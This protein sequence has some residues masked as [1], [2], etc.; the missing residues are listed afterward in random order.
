MA[1]E[2]EIKDK[3]EIERM[4]SDKEITFSHT[5]NPGGEQIRFYHST[6]DD[7]IYFHRPAPSPNTLYNPTYKS[8]APK[9]IKGNY[10]GMLK[11]LFYA[12]NNDQSQEEIDQ[13]M[14]LISH[15]AKEV[16]N[17]LSI[18]IRDREELE[19]EF[20]QILQ[21]LVLESFGEFVYR[22]RANEE[23]LLEK[24][25][26]ATLSLPDCEIIYNQ[27]FLRYS[28]ITNAGSQCI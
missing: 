28:E 18:T 25:L 22:S 3:K 23:E 8:K 17:M 15:A 21:Q 9:V 2:I 16:Y 20:T 19:Q 24:L 6:R 26:D 5:D 13:Q 7:T 27:L 1:N 10:S 12:V 4:S 14:N 11:K